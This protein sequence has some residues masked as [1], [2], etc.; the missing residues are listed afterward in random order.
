MVENDLDRFNDIYTHNI[1]IIYYNVLSYVDMQTRNLFGHFR[2]TWN[3]S[4]QY[5]I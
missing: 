1:I 4:P 5:A 3:R 2:G